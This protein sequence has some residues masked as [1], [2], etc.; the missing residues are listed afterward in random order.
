MYH[1]LTNVRFRRVLAQRRPFSEWPMM[2]AH[3]WARISNRS[4]CTEE[5]HFIEHQNRSRFVLYLDNRER[6]VCAC[7]YNSLWL[8]VYVLEHKCLVREGGMALA[9][10][11]LA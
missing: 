3:H 5:S 8:R 1:L 11:K 4:S 7:L 10:I 6:P 9:T 2:K